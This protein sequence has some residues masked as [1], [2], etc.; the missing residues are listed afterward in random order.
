M[1]GYIIS[2]PIE[3]KKIVYPMRLFLNE[4]NP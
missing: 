1:K 2:S 4:I 3:V